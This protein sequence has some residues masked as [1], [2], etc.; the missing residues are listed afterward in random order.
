MQGFLKV[1]LAIAIRRNE[2]PD[3]IGGKIQEL[4]YSLALGI[5][6]T[7]SIRIDFPEECII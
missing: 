5:A 1:L 3:R 2:D 4:E 7:K 6:A